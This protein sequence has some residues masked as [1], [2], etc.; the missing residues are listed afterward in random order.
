VK[1]EIYGKFMPILKKCIIC[2]EDFKVK[3][4]DSKQKCC[5]FECGVKSKIGK[6]H[7]EKHKEKIRL[8][9]KKL[10]LSRFIKNK[11]YGFKKGH[12]YINTGRTRWKKGR[13]P[14]NK[15][16]KGWRI[17]EKHPWIPK[18]KD[19]YN[20]QGGK[21]FEPYGLEF[22]ENLREVIRNRDRRK[23]QI[24]EK[25]ELDNGQKLI[26]HH[27]DYNKLNN[28]PKNLISLCRSCHG[29]TNHKK[30]YW[31]EYFKMYG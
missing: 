5:S 11:G 28:N 23:C 14:W 22:N 12:K 16:L 8:T 9:T 29:K 31:I 6:K 20:W 17:G 3:P 18:G 19:H 1:K 7:T 24:C 4:S 26:V 13:I 21:S 15:N 2:G 27:I 10:N 30:D 25:T